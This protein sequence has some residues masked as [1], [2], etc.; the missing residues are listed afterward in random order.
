MATRRTNFDDKAPDAP[1]QDAIVRRMRYPCA[2]HQCP[3]PGTI[4]LHG[5]DSG[6]VCAWHA[7][8]PE[9]DWPKI[10]RAIKDWECVH[11]AINRARRVLTSP[12][13]CVDGKAQREA[14]D[15]EWLAMLPAVQGSGWKQR[16][17]PKQG[18]NLA[19]WSRR[20][21]LFLAAR[22][23]EAQRGGGAV[24][25]TKPTLFA[26]EVKAGLRDGKPKG[27]AADNWGTA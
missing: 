13:T 8:E 23:H 24:D 1:A 26:A 21:D 3:M 5:P 17:Q 4:F 11:F 16:L 27:N 9:N 10:T 18:E 14:L 7:R 15:A 6:G 19:E 20:L 25:E 2:A 22:V 12:L